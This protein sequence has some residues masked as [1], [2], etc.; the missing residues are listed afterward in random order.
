MS[1]VDTWAS[2]G[3]GAFTLSEN[4]LYTLEAWRVFLDRLRPG[5]V[6]SVSRWFNPEDVSET[7]RLLALGIAALIDRGIANPIDHVLLVVRENVAT[8]MVSTAPFTEEDQDVTGAVAT[9]REFRIVVAPWATAGDGHL[10]R[11]ARSRSVADLTM[12]AA[13]PLFD[14]S[15]PTDSRPYYFNMLKPQALFTA[16][17]WPDRGAVAGN[18]RATMMLLV[19]LA[20]AAVLVA[21]IIL[22]PL[23]RAGRPPLPGLQFATTMAYFA[24]IGFA[25]MLIQIGLLQ[26]FAIYLGHPTYTLAIVL[27]AMLLFTGAGSFVSERVSI[28]PGGLFRLVPVAIAL[29]LV[30]IAL[31]LT[32]VLARTVGAGLPV[33]TAI[34]LLVAA[35]LSMLL[36]MCFPFGVRLVRQTP[37]LAAW[38]WGVNGA[39]GVLASIIAVAISIWIGI[40]ANF[41]LAAVM[42]LGLTGLLLALARRVVS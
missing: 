17:A 2:T 6:L 7:S 9:D 8:L 13:D 40:D 12:A 20:V 19:L 41:W 31:T 10:A 16:T 15:P 21:L 39:F 42:Y 23:V 36:G 18:L 32:H 38:A 29:S 3:A 33:R 30:L 24:T 5:G 37:S 25:Y 35:P 28:R 11:I 1:L 14:F 26:R 4:G 27:F 34:V 22:W